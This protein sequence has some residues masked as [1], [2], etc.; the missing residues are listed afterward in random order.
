MWHHC[1]HLDWPSEVPLLPARCPQCV[2]PATHVEALARPLLLLVEPTSGM[3]I[4]LS[5]STSQILIFKYKIFSNTNMLPL[6]AS[7]Q[8]PEWLQEAARATN[9]PGSFPLAKRPCE[10]PGLAVLIWQVTPPSATPR[11]CSKN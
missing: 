5:P 10:S 6:T 8:E 7:Q 4:G 2:G 9:P 1:W 3:K 11:I